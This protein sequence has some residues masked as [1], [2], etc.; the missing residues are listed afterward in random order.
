MS[1]FIKLFDPQEENCAQRWSKWVNIFNLFIS[2]KKIVEETEKINNLLYYGGEQVYET[3]E[4]VKDVNADK[5][6][7]DVIAKLNTS[8]NPISN[9]TINSYKF[10]STKQFEGEKFDDFL[11]R[12]RAIAKSCNFSDTNASV[13]D[14][15]IYGCFSD[16]VKSRAMEDDKL[17][18][19]NLIKFCKT[20]ET[21]DNHM[22]ELK[23][24]KYESERGNVNQLRESSNRNEIQVF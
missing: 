12:L 16:K 3:Y 22:A 18:L 9:H 1:E 21:V 8:F 14:Q 15:I 6:L 10:R 19:D 2:V 17:T 7:T 4:L 24:Q 20:I 23:K 11:D 5:L 13:K